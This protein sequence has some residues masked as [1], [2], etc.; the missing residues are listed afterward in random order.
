MTTD[1]SRP[2]PRRH[3]ILRNVLR[4]LASLVLT[5]VVGEIGARVLGYR[6][7]Q[8]LPPAFQMYADGRLY[9]LM[10]GPHLSKVRQKPFRINSTGLRNRK[11]VAK[12][13]GALRV[14]LLG[15]S[16]AFGYDLDDAD[17]FANLVEQDLRGRQIDV[18]IVNGSVPG[19]SRHQQR[20]FLEKFGPEIQPDL[21]IYTVV[22]N[23]LVEIA[24]SEAQ[25]R[26]SVRL[27]GALGWATQRSALANALKG[28]LA[29]AARTSDEFHGSIDVY[30]RMTETTDDPDIREALALE[31]RETKTLLVAAQSFGCPVV[32][33]LVPMAPQLV[34]TH[35]PAVL[36]AMQTFLGEQGV[37]VLD[38]WPLLRATDK[39][40]FLDR[41]HMNETG[42]RITARAIVRLLLTER[43]L[44]P[45]KRPE[46]T[47]PLA[48]TP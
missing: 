23:D 36:A 30:D 20:L 34:A 47:T 29:S 33:I 28:A 22:L 39:P 26:W 4:A 21:V 10:P 19:W 46:V 43:L 27:V 5:L 8:A 25:L 40:T 31:Q 1:E 18:E 12:R 2:R 44:A 14:L 38:L 45:A 17:V 48:P 35:P 41:V 3:R 37:T 7:E 11:L 15:D 6:P 42:H 16:V 24:T 13:P 9:F 32:A